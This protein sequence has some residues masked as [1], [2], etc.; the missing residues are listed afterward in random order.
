MQLI[1]TFALLQQEAVQRDTTICRISS[2]ISVLFM[3][4]KPPKWGAES[5][6]YGGGAPKQRLCAV[7]TLTPSR[8]ST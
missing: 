6:H 4:A 1:A 5:L 8:I 2:V 7:I 3:R